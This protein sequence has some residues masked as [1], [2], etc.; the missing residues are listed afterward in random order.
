MGAILIENSKIPTER[1][2]GTGSKA[3]KKLV[4]KVEKNI[5]NLWCFELVSND[6]CAF[7]YPIRFG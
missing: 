4:L 5:L 1:N 3:E 2:V 7:L 6:I